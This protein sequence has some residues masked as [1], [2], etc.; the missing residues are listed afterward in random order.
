MVAAVNESPVQELN[1]PQKEFFAYGPAPTLASGGYGAGKTIISLFKLLVLMDR[2]PGYRVAVVRRR[3]GELWKTTLSTL[4]KLLPPAYYDKRRGGRR[5]DQDGTLV[6][7]NGSRFDFIYLDKPDSSTVLRGLEINGFLVDQAE[8]VDEDAF[9]L[10]MTRLGRWDK[11]KIPQAEIDAFEKQGKPWPWMNQAG[12]VKLAPSFPLLTANPDTE[13]HWLWRRFHPDSQ[14]WR[15][16][17]RHRGY[18]LINFPSRDNK[19]LGQSNLEEMLSQGQDFI[20][21]YVDGVWGSPEGT[22]FTVPPDCIVEPTEELI[23]RLK[24]M[25]L[26]RMLDHGFSAPTCCGWFAV[27]KDDSIYAFREYYQRNDQ[28][29]EHR[30]FISALSENETY[31]ASL[32]DPAI[33]QMMPS[34]SGGRFSVAMEYSDTRVYDPHTAIWWGRADNNEQASRERLRQYLWLD[35]KRKHPITGKQG[36]PRL[37]FVKKTDSYPDGVYHITNETRSQKLTK[38]GTV[39]GKSIFSNDRDETVPDHGYD[40][41]RYMILS[42][43]SIPGFLSSSNP[44]SPRTF[45]GYSKFAKDAARRKEALRR[46]NR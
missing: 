14:D 46:L 6:L 13:L 20:K 19:F 16:T 41:L 9:T 25:S 5:N 7:S 17:F 38:V 29:R 26:Y 33:W 44:S 34:K 12:T 24:S 45:L 28:I 32:A 3:F 15:D 1:G 30:A 36:A 39:N 22:L 10:L 4:F 21:R 2:Y 40:V 23:E 42:R 31:R 37:F 43:P 35:P 27:D 11:V 8:E 18:K